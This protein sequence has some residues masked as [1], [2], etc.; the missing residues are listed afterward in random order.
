MFE[1]DNIALAR[2]QPP[3]HIQHMLRR[4]LDVPTTVGNTEF[5]PQ[6]GL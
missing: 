3:Q 6:Q 2:A 1:S 5:T 4:P